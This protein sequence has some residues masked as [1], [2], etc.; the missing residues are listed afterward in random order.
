MGHSFS[1]GDLVDASKRPPSV[2]TARG[3][4][5]IWSEMSLKNGHDM[6]GI[7]NGRMGSPKWSETCKKNGHWEAG[8]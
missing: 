2:A 6:N 4:N 5:S 7:K 1:G 8:G 3:S